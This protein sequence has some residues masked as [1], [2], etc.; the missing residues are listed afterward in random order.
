MYVKDISLDNISS[1][2]EIHDFLGAMTDISAKKRPLLNRCVGSYPGDGGNGL[3]SDE[4]LLL[5]GG[6]L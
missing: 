3:L 2:N 1:D 4:R 6:T 5:E